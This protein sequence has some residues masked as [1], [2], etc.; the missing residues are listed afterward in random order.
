MIE[1]GGL[2]FEDALLKDKENP[3]KVISSEAEH[4]GEE[5]LAIYA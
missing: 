4:Q 3:N 1:G 2:A 5:N